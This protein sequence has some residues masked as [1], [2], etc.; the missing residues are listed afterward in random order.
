MTE[1]HHKQRGALDVTVMTVLILGP[2]WLVWATARR[3]TPGRLMPVTDIRDPA[4]AGSTAGDRKFVFEHVWV[5][6]AVLRVQ[7]S[8]HIWARTRDL[9][10][11]QM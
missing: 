10:W 8:V 4:E 9:G 11:K 1:S 5:V 7:F 6:P 2:H 3:V